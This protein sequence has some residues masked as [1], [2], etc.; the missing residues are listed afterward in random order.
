MAFRYL[1]LVPLIPRMIRLGLKA[2]ELRDVAR[3][4]G[5]QR[6]CLVTLTDEA[7]EA[8]NAWISVDRDGEVT[9]IPEKRAATTSVKCHIDVFLDIIDGRLDFRTAVAHGL[10][11]LESHDGT[12][13][14]FHYALWSS[15][16]NRVAE[17]LG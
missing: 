17:I 7:G 5:G 11:E 9:V 13:W 6:S 12:P 10:V 14:F 15:F 16:W 8:L 4:Y 3:R 2:G 1:K